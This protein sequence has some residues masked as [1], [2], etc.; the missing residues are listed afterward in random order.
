[1]LWLYRLP[2]GVDIK[3]FGAPQNN[4]THLELFFTIVVFLNGF[5]EL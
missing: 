4:L 3:R 5:A 1:M 2:N